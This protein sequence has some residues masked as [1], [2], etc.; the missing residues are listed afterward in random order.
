MTVNITEYH[1]ALVFAGKSC[2]RFL[3]NGFLRRAP[4]DR[5]LRPVRSLL[6][7]SGGDAYS[8]LEGH[9]DNIQHERLPQGS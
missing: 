8:K 9:G 7:L 1:S 6:E 4:E 5:F 3:P 2:G